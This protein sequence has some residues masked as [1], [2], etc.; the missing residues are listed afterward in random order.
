MNELEVTSIQRGCVDDGEGVRTV[1]FFRGCPF[2]CP[3]CCNPET[4]YLSKHHFID[5]QKCLK[6]RN[7]YSPLC[8]VCER[9][10]GLRK[11]EDCPFGVCTPVSHFYSTEEL[12]LEILKDKLLYEQSG[13]GV[14]LSGGDPVL[15]LDNLFELLSE[16]HREKISCAI[17]TTLYSRNLRN[18][19]QSFKY[20]DE[21][22]VDLKLQ[23]ENWR[24]DYVA[25]VK[26]NLDL[27]RKNEKRLKFRLVYIDSLFLETVVDALDKLEV[28]SLE[29]LKC[30]ALSS[31]KY[32]QLGIKFEDYVPRDDRYNEFLLRLINQGINI[33]SKEI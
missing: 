31:R 21:W 23:Q 8:V 14:T 11:I 9:Y 25:V 4:I 24:S 2:S 18:N 13:G 15:Q 16:L 20:I 22:I 28:N 10:G 29:V 26:K 1:I 27:L 5:E 12:I 3:W 7:E 30:H 32:E 17:E 19:F 6:N 33:I